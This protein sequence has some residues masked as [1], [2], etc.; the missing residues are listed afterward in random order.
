MGAVQRPSRRNPRP[1]RRPRTRLLPL[2]PLVHR[3]PLLLPAADDR[4]GGN[5]DR[6]Q[7]RDL[8]G[9]RE[10]RGRS[11]PTVAFSSR[12]K[13][14]VGVVIEIRN[15]GNAGVSDSPSNSSTLVTTDGQQYSEAT[16]AY[17]GAACEGSFG[18]GANIA[19]GDSRSGCIAFK[20]P[21]GAGLT[22]SS[23]LQT[24]AS[25]PAWRSGT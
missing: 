2:R 25:V 22:S 23:S 8:Q 17:Q 24:V 3:H 9:H 7:W 12:G 19:P 5:A 4:A 15:I 10:A 1:H 6:V 18:S 21:D 16:I 20:V 14:F 13:R 11:A